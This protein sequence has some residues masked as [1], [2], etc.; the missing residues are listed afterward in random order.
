MNRPL[1]PPPAFPDS[2]VARSEALAASLFVKHER[3]GK[4]SFGEVYRG[5]NRLTNEVVAIKILNLDTDDDE[6]NDV[7]KEITMLSHCDSEHITR[8]HGAYLNETKLWVVM[9]Y[10]AGGSMR[11]ILKSGPIDERF[12]AIIAREV[13]HALVYLHKYAAIIHRDIKAA[14]ILLTDDGKV[15]LCD[16]GVAGQ[17]TMSSLR[18][19]SFVG[20]P[21]WMAPE[22][23]RRAQYDYKADIWS[24]GIT[25][26]ELATGNPPFADQDPRKAI[27]LIPRTRPARLEGKFSS[28]L[29]E[30]LALC[31]KE[32]PEERPTAEELLKTKFVRSSPRGTA[33]LLELLDRHNSAMRWMITRLGRQRPTLYRNEVD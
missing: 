19:N 15:K 23:I 1:P 21:Y 3:I 10:A 22:I 11:A 31:L 14:N 26:I 6:I 24:L 13:L 17:I 12:I 20:T 2:V 9:D 25:I 33:P 32:E 5:I 27:F 4:G 28:A 16:F 29:R 18:R 7:R 30:F 8:Y